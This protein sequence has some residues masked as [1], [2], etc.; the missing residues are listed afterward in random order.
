MIANPSAEV[1]D[2]RSIP[3]MVFTADSI[4]LV[5][6]LSTSSGEAPGTRTLTATNGMS[7]FGQRSTV[8]REYDTRPRKTSPKIST[9]ASTGLR[10]ESSARRCIVSPPNYCILRR[11]RRHELVIGQSQLSVYNDHVPGCKAGGDFDE[12]SL[13][14][15]QRHFAAD[16]STVLHHEEDG[17]PGRDQH[18]LLGDLQHTGPDR[19]R[20]GPA[21]ERHRAQHA[22]CI[23]DTHLDRQRPAGDR[24]GRLNLFDLSCELRSRFSVHGD[25][26]SL[27]H[28]EARSQPLRH[29]QFHVHGVQLRKA[30]D[31]TA[32]RAPSPGPPDPC[33]DVPAK[34]AVTA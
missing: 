25:R 31:P 17:V 14:F 12:P 27:T 22:L 30:N 28:P 21:G 29:G 3:L 26:D 32:G 1:D 20:D 15:A 5:T 18:G 11:A 23:R 4:L 9:E 33:A 16:R 10:T 2:S 7:M 6:S 8:S 19:D 13:P 24:G 34:G